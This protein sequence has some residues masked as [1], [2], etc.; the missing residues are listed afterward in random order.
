[1]PGGFEPKVVERDLTC[2]SCGY[3][4]RGLSAEFCPECGEHFDKNAPAL[5]EVPWLH[6]RR[7]GVVWAYVAT[8][9]R[10]VTRPA[11]FADEM[12]RVGYV[13]PTSAG[14][15]RIV[16]VIVA[17]I[18]LTLLVWAYEAR[19][20]GLEMAVPTTVWAAIGSGFFFALASELT[21]TREKTR[22]S[23]VVAYSCAPLATMPLAIIV[24]LAAAIAGV[25]M[26]ILLIL[27]I[28]AGLMLM[29]W[30][31]YL[32]LYAKETRAKWSTLIGQGLL[33]GVCWVGCAIVT[34]AIVTYLR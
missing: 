28:L 32:V 31:I 22:T 6:R 11:G 14:R 33:L 34:M 5:P 4:L 21:L 17:V 25:R 2:E 16:T 7:L 3:N 9:W 8:V 13:D 19:R 15:F 10:V 29:W 20:F 26:A 24:P 1:M 18:S 23:P 27:P 12:L 30:S